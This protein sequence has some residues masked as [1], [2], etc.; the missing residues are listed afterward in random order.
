M[1][2]TL[3]QTLPGHPVQCN[4][5]LAAT[6]SC[7]SSHAIATLADDLQALLTGAWC[8]LT[9]VSSY[10]WSHTARL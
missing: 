7:A 9:V 10:P 1:R 5:I 4:L 3:T 2:A 8:M 6:D